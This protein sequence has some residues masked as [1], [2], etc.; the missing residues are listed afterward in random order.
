MINY[1]LQGCNMSLI[2]SFS[3]AVTHTALTMTQTTIEC[4]N[5]DPRIRTVALGSLFTLGGIYGLLKS[6]SLSTLISERQIVV[7][8]LASCCMIAG[9]AL[10]A[11][12][13]L[14]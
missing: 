2:N 4:T 8:T 5:V 10:V 14:F 1:K 6:D 7:G 13:T 12:A 9:I 3:I 11:Q